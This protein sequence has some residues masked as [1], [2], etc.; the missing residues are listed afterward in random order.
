MAKANSPRREPETRSKLFFEK[1][2]AEIPS[3]K[4]NRADHQSRSDER[5][6][7]KLSAIDDSYLDIQQDILETFVDRGQLQRFAKPSLTA[8]GKRIPGLQLDNPGNWP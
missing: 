1:V 7:D 4:R 2:L 8:S 5:H 6:P 3:L